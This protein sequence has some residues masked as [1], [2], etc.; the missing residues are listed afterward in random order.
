MLKTQTGCEDVTCMG[1]V[2]NVSD[3][4]WNNQME[5]NMKKIFN[6]TKMCKY[7]NDS[8]MTPTYQLSGKFQENGFSD[9]NFSF[10][11]NDGFKIKI[12]PKTAGTEWNSITIDVN[13]DKNPNTIGRD[14][15]LYRMDER[16]LIHPYYGLVYSGG[17][18]HMYWRTNENLCGWPGKKVPQNS[19]GYGCTA[20]VMEENWSINY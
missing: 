1:F 11:T 14:I 15:F 20:R 10:M 19:T 17:N 9:T 18:T 2:G 4:N 5:A 6:I 13:G 3:E 16:G 8:C 12:M 7:G